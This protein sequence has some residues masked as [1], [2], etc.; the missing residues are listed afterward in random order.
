MVNEISTSNGQPV[1]FVPLVFIV[2]VT[3]AKDLFEDI[4]RRNSDK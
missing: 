1:I 3:A 4:S 2:L